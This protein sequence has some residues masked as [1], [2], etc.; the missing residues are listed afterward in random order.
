MNFK[1]D[2]KKHM[3]PAIGLTIGAFFVGALVLNAPAC[4]PG[5]GPFSSKTKEPCKD[6][7]LSAFGTEECPHPD[8]VLE[9]HVLQPTI[10]RCKSNIKKEED[11]DDS[12]WVA[13]ILDVLTDD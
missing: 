4:E 3:G 12:A 9:T 8:H 5:P 1:F 10:C 6:A 7:K 13:P 11:D 2:K